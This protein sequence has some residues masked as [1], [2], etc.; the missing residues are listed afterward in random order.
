[1][2]VLHWKIGEFE[3][4]VKGCLLVSEAKKGTTR[5]DKPFLGMKL[6]NGTDVIDAKKW[7]YN[8]EVPVVG[9]VIYVEGKISEYLSNHQLIIYKFRQALENEYSLSDFLPSLSLEKI[10]ELKIEFQEFQ[11]NLEDKYR[12][13][14]QE[15]IKNTQEELYRAPAA[16]MHHHAYIGGL[17]EHCISVCKR[18]IALAD[19][20]MVTVNKEL[21]ITGSLLHD[22]GKIYSYEYTRPPIQMSSEVKLLDHIVIGLNIINDAY[23]N[24]M[25]LITKED[26]LHI[27]HMIASHHGKLE[28]GSPIV[29][30]TI[31]AE[32]LHTADNLDAVDFKYNMAMQD[33]SEDQEWSEWIRGL[34]KEV[35]VK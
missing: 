15:I 2:A 10:E 33:K 18:S 9:D 4:I 1:M 34:G 22:I 23:K 8:D 21:L 28:W 24:T 35:W 32:I 19:L 3:G 20:S 31:E 11:A 17:L 29:P 5:N 25:P 7:D 12:I 30:K 14:I 27:Q 6:S 16:K 13:F 26:Y